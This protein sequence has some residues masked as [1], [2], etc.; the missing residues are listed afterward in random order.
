MHAMKRRGGAQFSRRQDRTMTIALRASGRRSSRD[1]RERE[2]AALPS[3]GLRTITCTTRSPIR[4]AS[5]RATCTFSA[6]PPCAPCDKEPALTSAPGATPALPNALP[7][8]PAAA[9][10]PA[11]SAGPSPAAP[12]APPVACASACICASTCASGS[13]LMPSC[14]VT[15]PAAAPPA[16]A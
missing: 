16:C 5:A 11:T 7:P 13:M 2:R 6:C 3:P 8:P 15:A 1:G 10:E 14:A 12:A 4:G 9:A